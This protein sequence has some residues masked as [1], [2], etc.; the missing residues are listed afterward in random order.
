MLYNFSMMSLLEPL[1]SGNDPMASPTISL[2]VAHFLNPHNGSIARCISSGFVS[3]SL[4]FRIGI[5]NV[6]M[7]LMK[8]C[9]IPFSGA[10]GFFK[11]TS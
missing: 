2:R 4:D 10:F 6:S 7:D 8:G 5:Y 9:D 3:F 11:V 1:F